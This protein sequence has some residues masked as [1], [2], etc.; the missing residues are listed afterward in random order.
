MVKEEEG[1]RKDYVPLA[2]GYKHR[3]KNSGSHLK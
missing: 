3:P 2:D 1:I